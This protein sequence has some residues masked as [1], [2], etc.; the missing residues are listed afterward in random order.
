MQ[1]SMNIDH[2]NYKIDF[3][4]HRILKCATTQLILLLA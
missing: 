3:M 2:S 4:S 1:A